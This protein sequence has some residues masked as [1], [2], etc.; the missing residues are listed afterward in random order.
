MRNIVA[1]FLDTEDAEAKGWVGAWEQAD[2]AGGS[3]IPQ[4]R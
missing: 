1:A 4:S 2:N 3:L